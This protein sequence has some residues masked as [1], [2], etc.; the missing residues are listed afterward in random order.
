[1]NYRNR[2]LIG[3]AAAAI[4]FI[5]LMAFVGPKRFTEYRKHHC[6]YERHLGEKDEPRQEMK[7]SE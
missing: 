4:T 5:S 2:F 6:G 7:E 3:L 1:M